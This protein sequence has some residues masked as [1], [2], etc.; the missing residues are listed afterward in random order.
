MNINFEILD[1]RAFLAVLELGSFNKAAAA[2]NLS[3]PAL[4]RRI[5]SLEAAIGAPLL[6]RTTRRVAPSAVGAALKP[7]MR[8]LIDELESQLLGLTGVGGKQQGQ[9]TLACV[10]TAAFYFLPQAIERFAQHYPAIRFRILD[11]SA[12]EALEAVARGEAEFG[13]NLTGVSHPELSFTPLLDDPFVLACRRDHP[14]ARRK[15][16]TWKD[17]EGH[18]LIGVSRS[19]GNRMI[20][21]A[22]LATAGVRLDFVYVVNHLN[23]SLG[24]VERGLGASVLPRLATPPGGHPLIVAVPIDKPTVHRAIG[25]VERRAG[26]LSPPAQRFRDMLKDMWSPQGTAT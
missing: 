17:L 8:R 7:M 14:L 3:Q 25:L 5:Q 16:L 4:S 12:N 9:V 20:L 21:D 18:R 26:R 19:S 13:V 24:L 11:L 15:T 2:L 23:T 6:E 1:L 22:A 10:P